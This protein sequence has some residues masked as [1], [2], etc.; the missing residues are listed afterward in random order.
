M[1]LR[2]LHWLSARLVRRVISGHD[3]PYLT[4]HKIFGWMPGDQRRWPLSVYLHRFHRPDEDREAPH[5]HP[6]KWAVAIVLAG[7]YTEKRL[8]GFLPA[9]KTAVSRRRRLGPLSINVIRADDYHLI[10]ELHGETWT[11]FIAGPKVAT[12]FFWVQGRGP[13]PWKQ[14]LQD[15]GLEVT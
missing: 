4:R 5:S 11:L 13:V 8:A 7:G 9:S 10:E 15:R 2:F 12:W 14:H 3:G 1:M 6:W